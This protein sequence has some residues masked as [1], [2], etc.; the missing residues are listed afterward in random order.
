MNLFKKH[1]RVLKAAEDYYV[2]NIPT[3]LSDEEYNYLEKLALDDGINPRNE[4]FKLLRGSWV[5]NAD[6]I[7]DVPKTQ[8]ERSMYDAIKEFSSNYISDQEHGM[9]WYDGD[10][11][12]IRW[13]PKYDG[14]SVI[15]YYENGIPYKVVTAGGMNK[16]GQGV[17]QTWKLLKYFPEVDPRIKSLHC[18]LLV[19]L[20][21]GFGEKSRQK[22]NGLV[23]STKDEMLQDV[24]DYTNIRAF[25]Y[26]TDYEGLDYIEVMRSL[27]EVR[28]QNGDIKFAPGCCMTFNEMFGLDSPYSLSPKEL[29]SDVLETST[30][31]FLIDGWVAYTRS[32]EVIKALK[33]KSAGRGE[34]SK[35]VGFKWNNQS[36]GKGN[37]KDS[38]SCNAIIDPI[39][40][41]GSIVTKPS[42][43]VNKIIKDGL[44]IGSLVSVILANSVIPKVDVVNTRSSEV[45]LPTCPCGSLITLD[46]VFGNN[47]KCPNLDCSYRYDNMSWYLE[48]GGMDEFLFG[49]VEEFTNL[50]YLNGLFKIDRFKFE[51]KIKDRKFINYLYSIIN[52]RINDRELF[53]LINELGL[54]G[55]ARKNLE[56]VYRPAYRA[57]CDRK[58]MLIKQYNI[59]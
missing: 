35:V 41:R 3:G 36:D 39:E 23:N 32:G 50:S 18:E 56:L 58:N 31:T 57:L 52:D 10:I 55:L 48:D 22:A 21:H 34:F 17:D 40:V 33:Y 25:R 11:C 12:D 16:N 42:C 24:E 43:P 2:N 30:G 46:S 59:N 1:S 53:D 19:S 13:I 6:Y 27:P 49:Y 15:C 5:D 14:S 44:G 47:L 28:N 51:D 38:W 20:E 7:T 9:V 37:G 26:F 54:T 29:D 4:A 45:N 8:I